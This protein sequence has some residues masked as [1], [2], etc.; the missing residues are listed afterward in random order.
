[1][2]MP[3]SLRVRE[4]TPK[5]EAAMRSSSDRDLK[6][7][8]F[9]AMALALIVSG[10]GEEEMGLST[11]RGSGSMTEETT[12]ENAYI[13]PTFLPGHC[14]IQFG[15]GAKMRFTVT[16]SS[17]TEAERLLSVSTNVADDAYL[18]SGVTIPVRS[19]VGFGQ[20]SAPAVDAGGTVPAVQLGGL[21][22]G[23]RPAMSA[24]VTFHFDRAGDITMPVPVEA[25]GR[26]DE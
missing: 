23:V 10:C 18:G 1:M 11:N 15:A 21:D 20:P 6:R 12:V 16:N 8:V 3:E 19:T 9:S 25:C 17:S 5:K 26:Q 22:P 7:S 13:V 2:E 24:R 4:V 14:A